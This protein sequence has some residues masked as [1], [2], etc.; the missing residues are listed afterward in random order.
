[1][2][3]WSWIIIW[4]GLVLLLVGVLAFLTYR[5]VIKSFKTLE[6]LGDLTEKAELLDARAR[7]IADEPR[8]SAVF[9]SALQRAEA[10]HAILGERRFR[11]QTRRER[12]VQRGK[13]LTKADPHQ[14][15]HRIK[16]T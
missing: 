1:M 7:D 13:L 12:R 5:I 10:W 2:P 8:E 3:W 15:F 14:F 11:R 16:R 9:S 6:A 4:G